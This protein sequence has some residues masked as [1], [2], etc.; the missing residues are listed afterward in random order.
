[1]KS[2]AQ[3]G[4]ESQ[5]QFKAGR[6]LL[7]AEKKKKQADVIKEKKLLRLKE[8]RLEDMSQITNTISLLS[9]SDFEAIEE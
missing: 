5:E 6:K 7:K 1:M 3:L 2:K 4:L 9:F 8:K